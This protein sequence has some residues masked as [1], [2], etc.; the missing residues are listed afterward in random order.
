MLDSE[1]FSDG[2]VGMRSGEGAGCGSWR[3]RLVLVACLFLCGLLFPLAGHAEPDSIY[4]RPLLVFTSF[5][6]DGMALLFKRI[7]T[8]AYGRIGYDVR[9]EGVPA[10]RALVMSDQGVVDG[11]AARVPVIEA[12]CPNLIRVP[13][14]LYMNRVVVF[15]RIGDIGL[16]DGWEGLYPYRVGVVRGYKFVD[17]MTASMNRV[18]APDYENLFSMLENGR[19]DI[20]VTE[21]FEALPALK[22]LQPHNVRILLPPLAYNPMYHYL[23]KRHADLVPRIDKVLREMRREGRMEALQREIEQERLSLIHI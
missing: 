17:K 21:Y 7:L 15:S 10:E 9:V 16:S 18:V 20:V 4:H 13:T 11:E 19:L 12:V 14:P 23:H 2:Q 5:P 1:K 6:C 22:E 8:E 3:A